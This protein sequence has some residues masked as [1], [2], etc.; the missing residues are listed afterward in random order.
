MIMKSRVAISAIS[1]WIIASTPTIQAAPEDATNTLPDAKPGQCYA[2][3]MIPANYKTNR[4]LVL[5]SEESEQIEPIPAVYQE[6]EEK[7]LVENPVKKLV[8]VPAKYETVKDRVEISPM[9]TLWVDSLNKRGVPV[10]E[11][12]LS[13][14]KAGGADL[15]S[16]I[17]GM[18]FREYFKSAQFKTENKEVLVGEESES[19]TIVPAKY[20]WVEEKVLVKEAAKNIVEVPA[21]YETVTEKVLIEAA[22]TV[23]KKG[24]GLVERID[25]TT[26][27]IMCLVEIPAQYEV[28]KKRVIKSP[29]TIRV[30]EVPAVYKTV[31]VRKLAAAAKEERTT[32]PAE[33]ISVS[34]QVKVADASFSWHAEHSSE[35]PVG[36]KTGNQICLK[37]IPAQYK[38]YKKRVLKAAAT[39]RTEEIPAVY[40]TVK[41]SK[42]VSDAKEKRTKIPAEYKTVETQSKVS[43]ERL[44]WQQVLCETNM[45]KSI[46]TQVQS[47]LKIAG[48][49]VGTVDGVIGGATLRA[50]DNYQRSKGLPRGGLT[51][52]TLETLGVNL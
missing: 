30:E 15:D 41:V 10:S 32:V 38:E 26:G 43:D 3:V 44:E 5:V 2:K 23:W 16:A 50:V 28:L 9:R 51:L 1:V 17:P 19:I 20:E 24:N 27:E 52:R 47:A 8:P 31:K 34:Q 21:A 33:F 14:A 22:K 49:D 39:V 37:E 29:A 48:F 45:T 40:K 36:K 46:V 7:I 25:N 4:E 12:L 11:A 18:C 42:L 6:V 13:A 35:K